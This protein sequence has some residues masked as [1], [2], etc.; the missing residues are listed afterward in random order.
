MTA[1]SRML[2]H[3]SW[4][5]WVM[6]QVFSGS[7]GSWS[8]EVT[9]RLPCT[10]RWWVGCYIW[11]S[12]E[13]PRRPRRAGAPPSPLLA[14]RKVTAHHQRPVYQLPLDSKGLNRFDT[15]DRRQTDRRTDGRTD[16][17][18]TSL[19]CF[20]CVEYSRIL[21]TMLYC[22]WT[23]II[24]AWQVKLIIAKL[25]NCVFISALP[26]CTDVSALIN[27]IIIM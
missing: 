19:S 8:L 21:I 26:V 13:G 18:A 7:H 12:E 4:V 23:Y 22:L 17:M 5:I 9:H 27:N 24:C 2:Y 16:R 20:S 1:S 14:V 10:L 25:C 15:W 3:G 6:G 11:C